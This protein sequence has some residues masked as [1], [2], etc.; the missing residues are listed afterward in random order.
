[1]I[2]LHA[3]WF[4][5]LFSEFGKEWG[6]GLV[7]KASVAQL[8]VNIHTEHKYFLRC[9]GYVCFLSALLSISCSSILPGKITQALAAFSSSW[10]IP[11]DIGIQ[12]YIFITLKDVI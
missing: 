7:W 10:K 5:L 6:G 4:V 8:E 12:W 11:P 3:L 9:E 1:M 2:Q